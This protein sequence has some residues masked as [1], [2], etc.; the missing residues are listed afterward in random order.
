MMPA[1]PIFQG[2]HRFGQKKFLNEDKMLQG[3]DP[4]SVP[5]CGLGQVCETG[6][7]PLLCRVVMK[8]FWGVRD[9]QCPSRGC[10]FLIV[11]FYISL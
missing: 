8:V 4:H 7:T 2:C 3:S 1:M 9:S 11:G 6:V 5:C 10:G